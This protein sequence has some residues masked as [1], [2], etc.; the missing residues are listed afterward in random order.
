[1]TFINKKRIGIMI[2]CIMLALFTFSFQIANENQQRKE[3][4]LA[5]TIETTSTPVSGKTVVLDAR[6]WSSR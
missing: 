1:M 5:E 6:P 2:T 3:L 4:N